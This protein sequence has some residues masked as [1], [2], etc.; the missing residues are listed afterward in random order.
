MHSPLVKFTEN[1]SIHH[2]LLVNIALLLNIL[3]ISDTILY[4]SP[5]I[6]NKKR[7]V[8]VDSVYTQ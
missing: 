8:C 7:V 1:V 2:V 4:I 3:K 6:I 5:F